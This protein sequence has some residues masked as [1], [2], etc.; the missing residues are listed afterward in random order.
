MG[1]YNSGRQG[2]RPTIQAT[3]SFVLNMASLT[4][5]GIKPGFHGK[6]TLRFGEESFPVDLEIDTR[7][8]APG[9]IDLTHETRHVHREQE[10][11]RYRIS[12]NTSQPHFGGLRY[13]FCCPRTG[14]WA[15]KLYLPLGGRRFLSREAY[16]LAYACQREVRRDRLFRK[17]R[18]MFWALG[19]EGYA[20]DQSAPPKPKGMWQRTY[21]RK[22]GD[23]IAIEEAADMA[24]VE[25]AMRIIGR[26]AR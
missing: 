20:M 19:G 13:W 14:T 12:L 4:R 9:F 16:R 3:Q 6:A 17:A 22:L 5:A 8:G 1:G 23:W 26:S 10:S 15:A 7:R 18:K 11:I 25:G 21:E 2:G 24:F